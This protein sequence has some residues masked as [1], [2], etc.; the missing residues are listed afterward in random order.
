M[1]QVSTKEPLFHIV[2]RGRCDGCPG[3]ADPSGGHFAGAGGLRVRHHGHDGHESPERIRRY[4]ERR[5][6]HGPAHVGHPAGC[7]PFFCA[8]ALRC[9]PPFGCASGTSAL[10]GQVLVGGYGHR[11]RDDLLVRTF[12]RWLLYA[13]HA[14]SSALRRAVMWGMIPA[15]FKAHWN[16]NETLFTLMLNYIAIQ[17][18]SF[19][20]VYL[21]KPQGF[22]QR[23]PH[24]QRRPRPAGFPPLGRER[25]PAATFSSSWC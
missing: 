23:R 3:V 19:A 13:A 21:G 16:T 7:R 2:K 20:I 14:P 5:G 8:S 6:G 25:L 15:F 12:P 24:Q 4:L 9:C 1:S 18:V 10:K 22:Q 11:C 17:L